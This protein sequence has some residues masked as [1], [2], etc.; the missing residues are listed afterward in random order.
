MNCTSKENFIIE[1]YENLY[2]V[3]WENMSY[4]DIIINTNIF[5][6]DT[7]F[8]VHKEIFPYI[9]SFTTKYTGDT[10]FYFFVDVSSVIK[11]HIDPNLDDFFV[12]ITEELIKKYGVSVKE[13]VENQS[14]KHLMRLMIMKSAEKSI[15]FSIEKIQMKNCDCKKDALP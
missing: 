11:K 15:E 12:P 3:I 2:D 13:Y 8:S 7:N 14:I 10:R 6:E 1:T 9:V 4:L 5:K